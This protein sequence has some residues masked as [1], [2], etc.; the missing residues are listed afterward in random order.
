MISVLW[1]NMAYC[2][3]LSGENLPRYSKKI[4]STGLRKYPYYHHLTIG[5]WCLSH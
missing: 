3:K 2:V 1:G 4:E 5:K